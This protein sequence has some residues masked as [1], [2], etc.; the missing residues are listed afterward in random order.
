M[1]RTERSNV[2]PRDSHWSRLTDVLCLAVV[3]FK[4]DCDGGEHYAF[5]CVG[6]S[7][8]SRAMSIKC[9]RCRSVSSE[10]SGRPEG[11]SLVNARSSSLVSAGVYRAN[12]ESICAFIIFFLIKFFC[13][14][15]VGIEPTT[16]CL[17]NSCS[18]TEL[19]W[20]MVPRPGLTGV[21][22]FTWRLRSSLLGVGALL[23]AT[24]C[25]YF[26]AGKDNPA[27]TE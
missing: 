17:Q 8:R 26:Q 3:G 6:V 25:R 2:Y 10:K 19:N 11:E 21:S 27:P 20:R 7:I 14:P 15:V 22:K 5:P 4:I 9:W 12:R 16:Y 18:T 23:A 1:P 13:E 24:E